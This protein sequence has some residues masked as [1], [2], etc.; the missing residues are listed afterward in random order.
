MLVRDLSLAVHLRVM[1]KW[2]L[3]T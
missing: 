1:R 3:V 2:P